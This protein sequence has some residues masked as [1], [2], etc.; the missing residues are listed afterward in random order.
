MAKNG[1]NPKDLEH[2]EYTA[3]CV[4]CEHETVMVELKAKAGKAE[5]PIVGCLLC[6]RMQVAAENLKPYVKP[7]N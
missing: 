5:G 4:F 7:D 3:F 6:G 1:M 2:A